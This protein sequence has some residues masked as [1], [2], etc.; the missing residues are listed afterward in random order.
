MMEYL[1]ELLMAFVALLTALGGGIAWVWQR[2]EKIISDLKRKI[3]ILEQKT[4]D[5][6]E[7]I[8]QVREENLRYARY[9]GVLIGIMTA[10][11]IEVPAMKDIQ[12]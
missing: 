2:V 12:Q 9:V 10:N 3:D 11:G 7:Q 5:Q 8:F 4:A 6:A 1:P